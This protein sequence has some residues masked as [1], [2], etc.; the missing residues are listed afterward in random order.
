[1]NTIKLEVKQTKAGKFI[2][3]CSTPDGKYTYKSAPTNRV[4]MAM[5]VTLHTYTDGRKELASTY[6]FGRPDLIGKGD[7]KNFNLQS[8]SSFFATVK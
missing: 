6:R 5:Y 7:S 4:Y 8:E 3:S 1:M 2:Y